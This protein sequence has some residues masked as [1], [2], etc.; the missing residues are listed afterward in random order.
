MSESQKK[1]GSLPILEAVPPYYFRHGQSVPRNTARGALTE[2]KAIG[3]AFTVLLHEARTVQYIMLRTWISKTRSLDFDTPSLH[4]F[5]NEQHGTVGYALDELVEDFF[6]G[7]SANILKL[8]RLGVTLRRACGL[9]WVA[10]VPRSC[11]DEEAASGCDGCGARALSIKEAAQVDGVLNMRKA[12]RMGTELLVAESWEWCRREFCRTPT[13]DEVR[14][15]RVDRL[16]LPD[17]TDAQT[18]KHYKKNPLPAWY[19][20]G[21]VRE[22]FEASGP[23][24]ARYPSNT[25]AAVEVV[26]IDPETWY[27]QWADEFTAEVGVCC[28]RF[29]KNHEL[30]HEL[31]RFIDAVK[32]FQIGET[33]AGTFVEQLKGKA[34]GRWILEVMQTGRARLAQQL[35]SL[36]HTEEHTTTTAPP[37]RST[38]PR[39]DLKRVALFRALRYEVGDHTAEVTIGNAAQIATEEAQSFSRSGGKELIAHFRRYAWGANKIQERTQDGRRGDVVKR[40]DTVI[41]MLEKWPIALNLAQRERITA[42]NHSKHSED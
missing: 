19:Q 35:S 17:L 32:S 26:P 16:G 23:D 28:E 15:F 39:P 18:I 7:D 31:A 22:R 13:K 27:A 3:P 36:L 20:N 38:K 5:S 34:K 4:G 37:S 33:E 9:R 8:E 1:A 25:L 2:G 21:V 14:K 24:D 40:Y 42:R 41:A 10:T 12:K 6:D 30:P 11:T 29:E